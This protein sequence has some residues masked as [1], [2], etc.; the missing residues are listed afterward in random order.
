M[1][2]DRYLSLTKS[3]R[4]PNE[5]RRKKQQRGRISNKVERCREKERRRMGKEIEGLQY[6]L[7]RL[8]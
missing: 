3:H 6:E 2:V 7:F 4:H 1:L 8:A 5:R